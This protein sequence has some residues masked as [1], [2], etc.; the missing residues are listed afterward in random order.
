MTRM[1]PVTFFIAKPAFTQGLPVTG[2]PALV[3]T[4]GLMFGS[5]TYAAPP[6]T[7]A[8]IGYMSDDNVTRTNDGGARLVDHSYSVSLYQPVI[9]PIA[10]HEQVML[11]G[12]LGGE[13]FDSYKGLSRLTETVHGEF[14]Y[15]K[16]S[17]F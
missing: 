14:Q 8:D 12:S 16:S 9:F 10:D 4:M 17:G 7:Q 13:M 1:T 15:R 6:D 5:G 2:L 3:L 11:T